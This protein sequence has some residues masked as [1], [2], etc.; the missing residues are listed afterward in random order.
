MLYNSISNKMLKIDML[1]SETKRITISFYKYFTVKYPKNFRDM[2]YQELYKLKIFGRIYIAKEGINAQVSVPKKY[3]KNMINIIEKLDKSLKDVRINKALQDNGKSFWVLRIKLKNSLVADG[4]NEKFNIYDVGTSLNA[5]ETNYMLNDPSVIF[6]DIRNQYEYEIGHFNRAIVMPYNTFRD[7]L[8]SIITTFKNQKHKK[9][10]I[11]CTGGIRCEKA[12]AWMKHHNFENVY[13]VQG[14]IIQYVR[15]AK[16]HGLPIY[17]KGKN[18]VFDER[19]QEHVSDDIISFCHQCGKLC[20]KH[21]NCLNNIC[22][23]LFIQC[24]SCFKKYQGCCSKECITKYSYK[25]NKH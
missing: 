18:F 6:I 11:Y 24:K 14:G 2:L 3:Y 12:S 4:I 19:M 1:K 9:I 23:K 5:E 17:F 10:V 20:D 16:K 21:I 8:L 22:H 7:Q 25:E 15:D 13:Q